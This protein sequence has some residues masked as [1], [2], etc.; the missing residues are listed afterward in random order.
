M[1]FSRWRPWLF[2]LEPEH[3]HALSLRV[4]G[5]LNEMPK[6]RAH[7]WPH[8]PSDPRLAQELWGLHFAHPVGLAAGF[9]KDGQALK[10]LASVG[11]AFLELGTVTPRPQPGNPGPRIFRYPQQ[12]AVINRLGFPSQGGSAVADRLAATLPLTVPLGI[13]IGKNRETPLTAAVGD[14]R[15][16]IQQLGPFA[17]YISINVSSPNTPELRRLQDPQSL[18]PLLQELREARQKLQRQPPLLLKIAPDLAPDEV[19]ALAALAQEQEPEPLLDGF[20]ATN[21]TL[22]RPS[23]W[24][25]PDEAGGL[26]GAPLKLRANGIIAQLYRASSGRLPIIGVGGVAAAEDVLDKIE[27][28]ASLVQLYTALI[29]EGPDLVQQITDA[30]PELLTAR[31]VDHLGALVG[32][33]AEHWATLPA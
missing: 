20:I 23:D 2:L 26:S 31:G 25:H 32:R 29:Y 9:D 6:T 19:T 13:N 8:R 5:G 14:Y 17:D 1:D 21:T 16:L 11:F 3:A 30:L 10:S 7:L 28:G 33:R 24:P 18:R 15:A 22:G 4:L 27:A 12:R